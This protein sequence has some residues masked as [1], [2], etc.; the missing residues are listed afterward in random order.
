MLINTQSVN[1]FRTSVCIHAQLTFINASATDA[2]A[3][4]SMHRFVVG[5]IMTKVSHLFGSTHAE[6]RA[7]DKLNGRHQFD[8]SNTCL[9][10]E[11]Q[12]TRRAPD[13]TFAK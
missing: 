12:D 13:E 4:E 10:P 5:G 8:E 9:T 11:R 6:G 3:P 2:Q 1:V 7:V